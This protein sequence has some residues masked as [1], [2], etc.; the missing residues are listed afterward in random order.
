MKVF[1]KYLD[2]YFSDKEIKNIKYSKEKSTKETKKFIK[3]NK[4]IKFPA[5]QFAQ[6]VSNYYYNKVTG[7][8][9]SVWPNNGYSTSGDIYLVKNTRL[10]NDIEDWSKDFPEYDIKKIKKY[11]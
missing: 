6:G 11:S 1:E 5:K 9:W 4:L 2:E 7:E 3:D 8:I 10:L